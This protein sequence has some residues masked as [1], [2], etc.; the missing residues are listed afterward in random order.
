MGRVAPASSEPLTP[1]APGSP[2]SGWGGAATDG[3]ALDD[4]EL[5]DGY[6]RAVIQVVAD[7]GPAVVHIARLHRPRPAGDAWLPAGSGSGVILTPDGYILTNAHVV[8]DAAGLEVRLADGRQVPA[9]IVGTDP[10]S[11]LAVA[12]AEASGLAAAALGNSDRL[13]VG[14]LV[15]AIGNPLGFEATVTAGVV[16]ALG[17]SLRSRAGRLIENVIQT[18]AAL[19]PGNSGGPLVDSHG[20][21]VGVNTAIIQGAQGLC[22]AVPA[23]TAAWVA[24]QLIARGRVRRVYLGI[25]G[26][27]VSL[28]RAQV[29]GLRLPAESAVLVRE[30]APSS[31]A[32]RGGIRSGDLLLSLN[33]LPVRS[34]DDVHRH[35]GPL[36][37]GDA[38]AVRVLRGARL[39]ELSLAAVEAS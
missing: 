21:V 9:R 10:D 5:L 12:R 34:V 7:V 18:D 13:R 25:A 17:R 27:T 16:S 20:R 4:L 8:E 3:A 14:Q 33:G 22:F 37:A 23:N 32:A 26:Q 15:V 39:Q 28:P 19:N 11:D 35:L 36:R 38:I 29:R 24:G 1:G 30:V 6:S 2:P 31:P